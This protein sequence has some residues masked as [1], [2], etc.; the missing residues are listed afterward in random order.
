MSKIKAHW[1]SNHSGSFL[2]LEKAR[3]KLSFDEIADFIRYDLHCYSYFIMIMNC[4][5]QTCG[6]NGLFDDIGDSKGDK[7]ILYEYV[8]EDICPVCQQMAPPMYCPECGTE[9]KVEHGQEKKET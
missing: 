2:V 1:D 8:G 3:G 6:G 7:I 5:E 9:I 4:C